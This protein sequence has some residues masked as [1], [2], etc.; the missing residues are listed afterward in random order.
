MAVPE[1]NVVQAFNSYGQAN[2]TISFNAPCIGNSIIIITNLRYGIGGVNANCNVTSVTDN[3]GNQYVPVLDFFNNTYDGSNTEVWWCPALTSNS[4]DV[5][6]TIGWT[7]I[8]SQSLVPLVVGIDASGLSGVVDSFATNTAVGVNNTSVQL[9]GVESVSGDLVIAGCFLDLYNTTVCGI[10]LPPG[11][12]GVGSSFIA[13]YGTDFGDANNNASIAAS[14]GYKVVASAERSGAN[15]SWTGTS[16]FNP[17]SFIVAFKPS[18]VTPGSNTAYI[19]TES[20]NVYS[21]ANQILISTTFPS[22]NV[23]VNVTSDTYNV[24]VTTASNPNLTIIVPTLNVIPTINIPSHYYTFLV[25]T[26]PTVFNINASFVSLS[27]NSGPP[28]QLLTN[29]LPNAVAGQAYTDTLTAV[30]GF[31]AYTWSITSD[32][33]PDAGIFTIGTTSGVLTGTPSTGGN[34]TLTIKVRDQGANSVTKTYNLGVTPS[35]GSLAITT[36]SLPQAVNNTVYFAQLSAT[37]GISYPDGTYWW[38]LVSN[39]SASPIWMQFQGLIEMAPYHV[40]NETITVQCQDSTGNSVQT[41]LGITVNANVGF[42]TQAVPAGTVGNPYWFNLWAAG[43]SGSGYTFSNITALPNGL[44]MNNAG[45]IIGTPTSAGNS[46]VTLKVNDNGTNSAILTTYLNVASS[47]LITRPSYNNDTANGFFVYKGNVYDPYGYPI[48]IRGLNR[49]HYDSAIASGFVG[50]RASGFNKTGISAVRIFTNEGSISGTSSSTIDEANNQFVQNAIIPIITMSYDPK[51]GSGTSG[52]TSDGNLANCVHWLVSNVASFAPIMNACMINMA[53]EWGP[54]N[55]VQWMVSTSNAVITLRNAGFTCPLVIDTGGSGQDE[56]DLEVYASQV[57]AN[58]HLQNIIFT[59]HLYGSA[60]TNAY[61]ISSIVSSGTTTVVTLKND[62]ATHPFGSGYPT[63]TYNGDTEYYLAGVQGMTQINGYQPCSVNNLGGTQGSWTVTLSV[64]STGFSPYSGG[65]T[66]YD[67]NYYT[68]KLGRIANIVSQNNICVAVTEFGPGFGNLSG[69][70]TYVSARQVITTCEALALGWCYWAF[71]DNNQ[72]GASSSWNDYYGATL[73]YNLITGANTSIANYSVPTDLTAMGVDVVL[74]PVYGITALAQPPAISLGATGPSPPPTTVNWNPGFYLLS[75]NQ[76]LKYTTTASYIAS[77][78]S[79]AASSGSKIVGYALYAGWSFFEYGSSGPPGNYSNWQGTS[80]PFGQMLG[81]CASN[82]MHLIVQFN[83]GVFNSGTP[84]APGTNYTDPIPNYILNNATTYGAGAYGSSGVASTGASGFWVQGTGGYCANWQNTNVQLAMLN[85][86]KAFANQWDGNTYFEAFV[87]C[88]DDNMYPYRGTGLTGDQYYITLEYIL[89]QIKSYF[90]H[91]NVALQMAGAQDTEGQQ[92]VANLVQAGVLVSCSDTDGNIAWMPTTDTIKFDVLSGTTGKITPGWVPPWPGQYYTVQL[93][94]GQQLKMKTDLAGSNA[95]TFNVAVSGS[96]S[97]TATKDL[98]AG[99]GPAMNAWF[100][101][102]FV[103]SNYVPPTPALQTYS[104]SIMFV[105]GGDI[106]AGA[107]GG[108]FSNVPSVTSIVQ[109]CNDNTVGG[110]GYHASHVLFTYFSSIAE[111]G[112]AQSLWPAVMA[113]LNSVSLINTQYP[114]V[115]Q[116]TPPSAPASLQLI[117][118]G[119]PNT[120]QYAQYSTPAGFGTGTPGSGSGVSMQGSIAG[121]GISPDYQGLSW[122]PA[123]PGTFPV[124]KYN[125]YRNGALYDSIAIPITITGYITPTTMASADSSGTNGGPASMAVGLLTVTSVSGGTSANGFTDGLILCGLLLESNASGFVSG[126]QIY[127]YASAAY[128]GGKT[129][130]YYVTYSQTVGSAGA[131]ATFTGWSFNDTKAINCIPFDCA[132]IPQLSS[133]SGPP[134]TIYKYTVTAV[135]TQGNEGQPAYPVAYMYKGISWTG[136]ANYTFGGN[137]TWNDTS[138]LPQNGPYDILVTPTNNGYG[139]Q[140]VWGNAY[141]DENAHT[142]MCPCC[143]FECGAFNYIVFDIKPADSTY[144]GGVGPVFEQLLRSYGVY[145]GIDNFDAKT[146]NISPYCSPPLAAGQW[147]HCTLPF[148]VMNFGTATATGS[149]K[150]VGL[151]QGVLTINSLSNPTFGYIGGSYIV[152]GPGIPVNSYTCGGP[153]GGQTTN[154]SQDSQGPY[155]NFPYQFNIYGPNIVGNENTGTINV[156]I[157]SS[158]AYK[159]SWTPGETL[160]NNT[161]GE[162]YLN[163]IGFATVSSTL[164]AQW[165]D[166]LPPAI[167]NVPYSYTLTAS[168]GVPP[169]TFAVVSGAL[170]TGLTLNPTTGLVSG[171]PTVTVTMETVTFSVTD[172]S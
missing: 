48:R 140:P 109:A 117:N 30:G 27:A 18:T 86:I 171:T 156:Y 96:P 107:G 163:N 25:N 132:G 125:I 43:G 80:S 165:P 65:G 94:T 128:G 110:F 1:V 103:G 37:G 168:G 112:T 126:T 136:F 115:Y 102:Q 135:D 36:S 90:K 124:S 15:W 44:T 54:S 40:E 14:I 127:T 62:F 98:V 172:N 42:I 143:H 16:N 61:A 120:S 170:P 141:G 160:P 89:K 100:G 148:S 79:A 134:A 138:G 70:P 123:T 78:L 169:Y 142:Y 106:S 68:L 113:N 91:T 24:Y 164:Q 45:Y 46:Q 155:T 6:V 99:L 144:N 133:G 60:T 119:G 52:N 76:P 17:S 72:S 2:A 29:S 21:L 157:Q 84:S 139:F 12:D 51:A 66:I 161:T 22:E 95:V 130:T 105:E 13:A 104:T 153:N 64:N 28:L 131:P 150:G 34:E 81:M 32:T 3:V 83:P 20:L 145:N 162:I 129:G 121:I 82:N 92:Y 85:T 166:P 149:F 88:A 47:G 23:N 31:G 58:D 49:N 71:D 97:L 158:T 67:P 57:L 77:D 122:L 93:S 50:T 19:P 152:S 39:T 53:N 35:G 33:G 151:Y 38:T 167:E 159:C 26:G 146:I 137:T 69:S 63:N 59:Y 116:S 11:N 8:S 5:V 75:Y 87:M 111:G 55:S 147:S 101:F 9:S 4:L 74:N 118:Q 7:N 41:T 73:G 56:F 108:P 10:T 114:P 154:S